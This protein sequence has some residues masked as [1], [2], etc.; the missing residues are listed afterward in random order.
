MVLICLNPSIAETSVTIP[1][2]TCV[3]DTGRAREVRR[4]KRTSTSVLATDWCSKASAKQRAGRAGRVQ[5][6][7]ALKLYSLQT[8][9]S[10]MKP[11]SEP[12]LRRVPLEEVCLSILAC[13]FAKSCMD[14]LIQAPQPPDE[15]SVRT[16]LDTLYDVGAIER[17]A[18]DSANTKQ[19]ECLTPLGK[20]LA[21]LPV[22]V[23]LGKMLIFGALFHCID[24]SELKF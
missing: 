23:R 18:Q 13:G 20:H 16:A 19:S 8:A 2:V 4:N 15:E 12:E 3:I 24:P 22:D 5:S 6:G 21:R 14:F 1:D 10:V 11:A 9:S 17:K 7:L